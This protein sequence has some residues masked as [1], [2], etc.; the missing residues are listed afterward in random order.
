MSGEIQANA[1]DAWDALAL[2]GLTPALAS[3]LRSENRSDASWRAPIRSHHN[4]RSILQDVFVR[5][6][7][8]LFDDGLLPLSTFGEG[9]GRGRRDFHADNVARIALR[10]FF[11]EQGKRVRPGSVCLEWDVLQ[12]VKLIPGCDPSRALPY[13]Y[14]TKQLRV[15]QGVNRTGRVVGDITRIDANAQLSEGFDVILCQQVFEHV[16]QPFTAAGALY[17]LL[18]PG[19]FVFW[20]APFMQRYHRMPGDYFRFTP[21]GAASAFGAAGFRVLQTQQ[22]GDNRI[23]SGNAMGFGVSDFEPKYLKRHLLFN[24]TKNQR[25]EA[26]FINTVMVFTK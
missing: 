19:G 5:L 15:V 22:I 14:D 8:L 10:A 7:G 4:S 1:S 20:S 6:H 13:H 16:P 17:R 3:R 11:E 26:L 12:Y 2:L 18:R 25:E 24:H 21:E 23:T 9:R